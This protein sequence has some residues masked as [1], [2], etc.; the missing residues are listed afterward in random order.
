[1]ILLFSIFPIN[2]S[3]DMNSAQIIN[4][5]NVH[6]ILFAPV[7]TYATSTASMHVKIKLDA[8]QYFN[9]L[10]HYQELI[11]RNINYRSHHNITMQQK[12]I[13]AN[14][15]RDTFNDLKNKLNTTIALLPK[16]HLHKRSLAFITGALSFITGTAF[17]IRNAYEIQHIANDQHKIKEQQNFILDT[18]TLQQKAITHIE[19]IAYNITSLIEAQFQDNPAVFEAGVQRVLFKAK[20]G[21]EIINN[22]IQQA[23]NHRLCINL[24]TYEAATELFEEIQNRAK[25][26]GY[27]PLIENINDLFQIDTSYL[28][29]PGNQ[30]L[31]IVHVPLVKDGYKYQLLRYIPFPLSQTLSYNASITPKVEKDLLAIRTKRGLTEHKILDYS[32]LVGCDKIGENYRCDGRSILKTQLEDTCLGALHHQH[33]PGVLANC[34]FEI[35]PNQEHIFELSN[36][37]FLISTPE[38]FHTTIECGETSHSVKIDRLSQINIQGG[39]QVQLRQHVIRPERDIFADFKVIRFEWM[40]DP[41]ELF[42]PI[43]LPY[44]EHIINSFKTSG[45]HNIKVQDIQKWNLEHRDQISSSTSF[46]S[47]I[48]ISVVI[49]IVF[50]VFS[51]YFKCRCYRWD[52]CVILPRSRH[53]HK[54]S[55]QELDQDIELKDVQ[56]TGPPIIKQAL[57]PKLPLDTPMYELRA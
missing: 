52:S 23:Q 5:T 22:A 29:A 25:L 14:A 8:Q 39:C 20:E 4:P 50:I 16:Q 2:A 15:A 7:G 45:I 51:F 33:L 32:D 27:Q 38:S 56:F 26:E 37:N 49:F 42:P 10:T 9:S 17:G 47:I 44:L 31:L 43:H 46:I 41:A 18:L 11:N 53:T 34:E 40:W 12:N 48:V 6:Q 36:S 57:Y 55:Q 54:P 21:F 1:M 28:S 3:P 30:L 13:I 19:E 35:K 24:L